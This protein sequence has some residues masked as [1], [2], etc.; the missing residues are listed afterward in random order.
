MSIRTSIYHLLAPRHPPERY[1]LHRK[2]AATFTPATSSTS[3]FPLALLPSPVVV[4]GGN[5]PLCGKGVP[6]DAAATPHRPYVCGNMEIRSPADAE[7][8]PASE[9]AARGEEHR[10]WGGRYSICRPGGPSTTWAPP[11]RWIG[12]Q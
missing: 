3:A 6:A 2:A 9:R 5:A 4:A 7:W 10:V 12:R 8:E 1:T 11:S